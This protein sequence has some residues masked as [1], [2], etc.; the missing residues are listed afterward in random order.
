MDD[1]VKAMSKQDLVT[2]KETY[3]D[4]ASIQTLVDGYIEVKEREEAQAQAKAS[5]S[6][7]I[8]KLVKDLPHPEDVHNVYMAWREVEEDDTSQ[9]GEVVFFKEDV[10]VATEEESDRQETRYPKTKTTR[11]VVELNKGFQVKSG[12][13]GSK[14]TASK[15][16]ITVKKIEENDTLTAIGNF[17]SASKACEHLSIPT[18]GDSAVRVLQREGYLTQAYE[19]EDIT[20]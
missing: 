5:F 18:G 3:K 4:N 19:G 10:V 11:W 7:K 6:K 12:G 9:D 2:F 14:T 13:G 20:T 1:L 8:E 16:A 17:S 15:R